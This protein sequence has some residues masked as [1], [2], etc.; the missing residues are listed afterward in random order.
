[1]SDLNNITAA[2]A[3]TLFT[4]FQRQNP[5]RLD[6]SIDSGSTGDDFDFFGRDNITGEFI[7]ILATDDASR[8]VF[9]VLNLNSGVPNTGVFDRQSL[10]PYLSPDLVTL[11]PAPFPLPTDFIPG[12]VFGNSFNNSFGGGLNSFSLGSFSSGL[13]SSSANY[14]VNLTSLSNSGIVS[15]NSI[16]T[17]SFGGNLP[18]KPDTKLV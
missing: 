4:E 18:G 7:Y 1:M 15:V 14:S 12:S 6:G 16:F 8:N 13:G 9:N 3:L 11:S 5:G 17:T 10:P 2:D